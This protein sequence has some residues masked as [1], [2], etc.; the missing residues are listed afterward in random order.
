VTCGSWKTCSTSSPGMPTVS[1]KW[2][3]DEPFDCFS[4]GR[5]MPNGDLS[6]LCRDC[7]EREF[8]SARRESFAGYQLDE[9]E[10]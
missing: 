3:H 8:L 1:G 2:D 7:F 6:L 5:V 9:E 4:C 10:G